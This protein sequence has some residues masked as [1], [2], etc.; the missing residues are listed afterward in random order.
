LTEELK[1]LRSIKKLLVLLLMKNEV[2]QEEIAKALGVSQS[3]VSQMVNPKGKKS[4]EE[5]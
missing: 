4:A 3:A 5:D 2:G 1:E